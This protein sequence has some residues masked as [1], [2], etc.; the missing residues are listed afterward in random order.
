[1][2]CE[3]TLRCYFLSNWTCRNWKWTQMCCFRVLWRQLIWSVACI[4][5]SCCPRFHSPDGDAVEL[6]WVLE[7]GQLQCESH[8]GLGFIIEKHQGVER[9]IKLCL[10]FLCYGELEWPV[11]RHHYLAYSLV[12]PWSLTAEIKYWLKN[13]IPVFKCK[14]AFFFAFF[15]N[16]PTW[17]VSNPKNV[18]TEGKGFWLII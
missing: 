9:S 7:M 8:Q 15:P 14:F 11:G 4:E 5:N 16:V 1:M 12:F 18:T 3:G 17:F 6:I 13:R 10:Y 2:L